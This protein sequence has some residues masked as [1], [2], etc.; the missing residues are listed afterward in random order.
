MH[1][2]KLL[3]EMEMAPLILGLLELDGLGR[4]FQVNRWYFLSKQFFFLQFSCFHTGPPEISGMTKEFGKRLS[5]SA[6]KITYPNVRNFILRGFISFIRSLSHFL[7][8]KYFRKGWRYAYYHMLTQ[9][10]DSIFLPF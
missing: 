8:D 1:I 6:G 7:F 9:V 2:E 4:F 5:N 3:I 10:T